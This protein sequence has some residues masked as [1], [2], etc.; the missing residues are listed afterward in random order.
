[1]HNEID[2]L[3]AEVAR[4]RACLPPGG[5][6]AEGAPGE[7]TWSVYAEK[8]TEENEEL[9]NIVDML[10]EAE[11][12]LIEVRV[13]LDTQVSAD[14]VRR[15]KYVMRWN[16]TLQKK[17]RELTRK[18]DH[19]RLMCKNLDDEAEENPLTQLL[20]A[21]AGVRLATKAIRLVLDGEKPE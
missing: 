1:M 10:T 19:V 2:R 17:N 7:G 13:A 18:L 11:A 3:T 4:L 8:L 21:P 5:G 16:S 12:A 14:V 20:K 15:A 6:R 9:R